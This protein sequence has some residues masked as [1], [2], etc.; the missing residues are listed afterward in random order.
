MITSL[1][2]VLISSVILVL[3]LVSCNLP[4]PNNSN[5]TSQTGSDQTN[6]N[7]Q[8]PQVLETSAPIQTTE[9]PTQETVAATETVQP[10]VNSTATQTETPITHVTIPG[11]PVW[12]PDQI[13]TDCNTGVRIPA[14]STQVIISGCDYW[15][16]EMIERPADSATGTYI[17]ALDIIWS[18]AGKAEPWIFLKTNV[19]SLAQA[20]ADLKAAFELDPDLDSRG[21]FLVTTNLPSSTNWSTDGVQVWQDTNQ[22]NGGAIA[23]RYDQNTA[24]GYETL[25]FDG[26]KGADPDLAWSRISPKNA[27]NIEFAFKAS[28]L[29]NQKVFGWW[30]WVGLQ[31]LT[32]DKFE[33]V[34]RVEEAT[35]W[36]VDN[37][38]SWIFGTKPT[39]DQLL[40]LCVVVPPTPTPAPTVADVPAGCKVTVCRLGFYFDA[41]S[42]SC[43][44]FIIIFPPT[45][46]PIIIY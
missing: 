10:T 29:P 21:E 45:N 37:S 13:T 27:N 18:Q 43:K 4:R 38:C 5:N 35:T 44:R 16:R 14:G 7:T 46:T 1:K 32:A 40:N 22:D 23:F 9:A 33:L 20:P 26:G 42:C 34:D 25:L 11:D 15:N 28:L 39:T 36:N 31:P 24:D 19:S 6:S 41:A 2:R 3:L 17:P 8:A 30:S 12:N